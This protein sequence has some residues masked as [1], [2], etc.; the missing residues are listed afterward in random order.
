MHSMASLLPLG[1]HDSMGPFNSTSLNQRDSASQVTQTYSPVTARSDHSLLQYGFVEEF[2]EPFLA[3][4]DSATGFDMED[5]TWYG[6]SRLLL[7]SLQFPR[8]LAQ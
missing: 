6:G 2:E 7:T 4:V 3:A 5:D 8:V 1:V